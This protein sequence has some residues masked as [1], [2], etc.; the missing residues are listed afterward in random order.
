MT[1]GVCPYCERRCYLA[2]DG[3]GFCRMYTWA[4]GQV[5]ERFPHRYSCMFVNHIETVPFYHFQP[6]SR[7]FVL[8]GAGCNFDCEYCSNAY[9]ARSEP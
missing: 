9:V 2:E 5:V 1:G 8:G 4:G 3:V 6:G 7:T